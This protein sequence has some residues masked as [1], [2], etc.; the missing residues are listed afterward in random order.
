MELW[1]EQI[2]DVVPY[3]YIYMYTYISIYIY[4][5]LSLSRIPWVF[6]DEGHSFE[7][8]GGPG[9][10]GSYLG[11]VRLL[12]NCRSWCDDRVSYGANW[13]DPVAIVHVKRLGLASLEL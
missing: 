8:C 7:Y 4:I 13:S 3:I 11:I 2:I 6:L 12:R 5:S 9:I 10:L 1:L